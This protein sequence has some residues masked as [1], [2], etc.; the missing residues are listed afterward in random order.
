[1]FPWMDKKKYQKKITKKHTKQT[2]NETKINT[3]KIPKKK[4]NQTRT[5]SLL[6]LCQ[7][8]DSWALAEWG[9][10]PRNSVTKNFYVP[11]P[12]VP[13]H[14]RMMI[15]WGSKGEGCRGASFSVLYTSSEEADLIEMKLKEGMLLKP[16]KETLNFGEL[17]GA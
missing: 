14:P 8:T 11:P 4:I 16:K 1:M 3:T 2:K 6:T 10:I 7:S 5:W 13:W 15:K 9:Y 12:S 17:R